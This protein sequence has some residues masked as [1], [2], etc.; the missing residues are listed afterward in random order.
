M[1]A[2][3]SLERLTLK[4][5]DRCVLH[6]L[7]LTV[8][9][10]EVVA[11]LGPSG[12]G[13]T[14]V[15]RAILGFETP[16]SGAVHLAGTTA[17]RDGRLL[18]LPEERGLAVVFQDLA[19]WP[20]PTVAGHLAFVLESMPLSRA[21]RSA[22]IHSMLERV[23]LPDKAARY[24]GEL[25]GGER[26]RVAIARALVSNPR[27]VLLDEPL[28]NLDVVRKSDQLR[29]FREL[30]KAK[31]TTAL[32][33]THDLREAVALGDRIAVIEAG[34]IT[35]SATPSELCAHPATAF[36]QQLVADFNGPGTPTRRLVAAVPTF[37]HAGEPDHEMD[38]S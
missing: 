20:H 31:T 38:H 36:V 21:E 1:I 8:D 12:S 24:P 22:H 14:S 11:L 13:K 3:I 27:A 2:A 15:L 16:Q 29:L 30:L 28:S 4:F 5:A 26:Q 32:Y 18:M 25:S 7:S 19:L 35:Q 33:V 34:R 37:I 9:D 17:S 6:D 10:G 23:G